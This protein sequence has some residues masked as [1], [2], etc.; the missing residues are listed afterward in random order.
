LL[1]D[2][3]SRNREAALLALSGTVVLLAVVLTW[4]AVVKPLADL[5]ARLGRGEIVNLN[6]IS[7]SGDLLPLLSFLS[8]PQERSLIADRIR[9]RAS[10][11]GMDNVGEIGRLRVPA[12][13]V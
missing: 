2:R 5:E 11:G 4:L 6:T 12:G 8:S 3:G 9:E 13:E 7:R 1:D 10:S